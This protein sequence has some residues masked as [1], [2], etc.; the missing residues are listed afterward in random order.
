[1][2]WLG[3]CGIRMQ[4]E[5]LSAEDHHVP[6]QLIWS[7]LSNSTRR[8]LFEVRTKSLYVMHIENNGLQTAKKESSMTQLDLI[9]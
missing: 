5:A 3:W 2:V 9:E 8:I 1:V 4:A 6:A 7:C